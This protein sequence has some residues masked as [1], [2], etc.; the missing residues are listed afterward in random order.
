M[1]NA[2]VTRQVEFDHTQ[3]APL[4]RTVSIIIG[5]FN[6]TFTRVTDC[7]RKGFI[8]ISAFL[9]AYSLKGSFYKACLNFHLI[10]F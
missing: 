5:I 6:Y 3:V 10:S 1:A 7:C 9:N 4:S 2:A 8:Q